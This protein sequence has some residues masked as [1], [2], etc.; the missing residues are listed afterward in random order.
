MV[1]DNVEELQEYI[2]LKHNEEIE[3]TYL[4]KFETTRIRYI[5]HLEKQRVLLIFQKSVEVKVP[6]QE[7]LSIK[8]KLI[9]TNKRLIFLQL[10]G[11]IF[12]ENKV[13]FAIPYAQIASAT[14]GGM[15]F[16][17]LNVC[18]ESSVSGKTEEYKF[19]SIDAET[20]AA[21]IRNMIS[22]TKNVENDEEELVSESKEKNE[23]IERVVVKCTKCKTRNEEDAKF[24][25]KCG[26]KL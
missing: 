11:I 4:C 22:T 10:K 19:T 13:L 9:L 5:S 3:G 15:I 20:A 24:C 17:Y 23:I 16:K 21:V 2:Q 12:G 14:T 8:G 6:S 1:V 18:A 26:K 25:K 7:M